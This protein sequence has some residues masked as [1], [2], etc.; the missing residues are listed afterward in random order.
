[1][2][3][4]NVNLCDLFATLA[5]LAGLPIPAGLDSRSLVPLMR[6]E[7]AGW[8]NES[9]SQFGTTNYMIVRDRLKYQW[10]G[11]DMPE[12]LFDLERDP[13]ETANYADDPA[14]APA[15]DAFRARLAT[16]GHGPDA[17]PYYVNA[18]Y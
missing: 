3:D 1:V 15:M 14:Y 17:D 11:T 16:L 13:G 12:M 2:V 9:L 10:Y 6:G 8:N 4:Q 18:G 5:D 7:T